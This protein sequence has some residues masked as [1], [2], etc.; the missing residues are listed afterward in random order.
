LLIDVSHETPTNNSCC[1]LKHYEVDL[2]VAL[3]RSLLNLMGII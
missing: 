1:L 2:L 3:H